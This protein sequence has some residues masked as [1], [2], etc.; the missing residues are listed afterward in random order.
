MDLERL[1]HISRRIDVALQEV[2]AL[3]REVCSV[4]K[5]STRYDCHLLEEVLWKLLEARVRIAILRNRA[6]KRTR[7]EKPLY[8]AAL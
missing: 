1:T 3:G 7:L 4:G 5:A 6:S 8:E 2:E